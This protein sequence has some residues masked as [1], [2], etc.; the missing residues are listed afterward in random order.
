[1][2]KNI[3]KFKPLIFLILIATIG[4]FASG[5][6][7]KISAAFSAGDEYRNIYYEYENMNQDIKMKS[8]YEE[9][10]GCLLKKANE[11]NINTEILHDEIINELSIISRENDIELSIIKFSE[12]MPCLTDNRGTCMKVT[13]EFDSGF[14]D[15]LEFVD[16]V[17]DSESMISIT[18]ISV[19]TLESGV[20]VRVN[21]M[22]YGLPMNYPVQAYE[23]LV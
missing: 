16:D 20:H 18:D 3:I 4:L 10:Q 19:L 5:I 9:N 15:M 11:L 2:L 23:Q 22:F 1:M 17:K 14:D 7:S 13:V 21:L 12:V 6:F 8:M